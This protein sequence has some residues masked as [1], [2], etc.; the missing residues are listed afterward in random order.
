MVPPRQGPLVPPSQCSAQQTRINGTKEA[1]PG[2]LPTW[3]AEMGARGS[4]P[5]WADS[6]R[7]PISKISRAIWT[8]VCVAQVVKRLLCN[9]RPRVQ[10]PAPPETVPPCPCPILGSS[11][12]QNGDCPVPCQGHHTGRP[13]RQHGRRAGGV[14]IRPPRPL[15]AGWSPILP[16][17]RSYLPAA[18]VTAQPPA[19]IASC[20][21][22]GT[23]RAGE[24]TAGEGDGAWPG[25]GSP[26]H[27]P[28]EARPL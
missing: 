3:E 10:T 7:D 5:A 12:P 23:G 6:S 16:G 19:P 9:M 18:E 24:A 15:A 25:R 22:P 20:R 21:S 27:R 11:V 26:A 4:R 28:G 1:V 17:R 2:S 14:L 13:G 8:G